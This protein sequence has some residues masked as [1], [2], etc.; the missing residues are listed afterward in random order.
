MAAKYPGLLQRSTTSFA[1]LMALG[2]EFDRKAL[3][4]PAPFEY[5]AFM[6]FLWW[7][8]L[9]VY[10]FQTLAAQRQRHAPKSKAT[11]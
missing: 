1:Y 11:P 7:A 5:S 3:G 8:L 6:F 10:L 2:V 4:R 9:P